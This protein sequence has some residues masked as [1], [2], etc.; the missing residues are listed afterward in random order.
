MHLFI[1][2]LSTFSSLPAVYYTFDSPHFELGWGSLGFSYVTHT[3]M[4]VL[5]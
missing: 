4:K 1:L 5:I 3:V 2:F